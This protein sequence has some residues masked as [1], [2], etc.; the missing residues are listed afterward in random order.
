MGRLATV[1]NGLA[2]REF[3]EERHVPCRLQSAFS[4]AP[5]LDAVD[6]EGAREAMD[7][8]RV[9]IFCGGTGLPYFSTDTAAAVRA[10]DIRADLLAKASTVDAVYDVDPRTHRAAKAFEKISYDEALGLG[11][12]VMDREALCLCQRHRLPI[13]VFSMERKG[14]LVDIVEGKPVGTL[15]GERNYKSEE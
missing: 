3:L 5:W 7:R 14:A 11:S 10:L 9:V 4:L 1:L 2:L 6:P 13:V 15:I 12:S 8:G